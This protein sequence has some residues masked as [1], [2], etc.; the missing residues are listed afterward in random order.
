MAM[1][2]AA[3]ANDG[4]M[5]NGAE[6]LTPATLTEIFTPQINIGVDPAI[7]RF[8]NFHSYGIGWELIDY[9]GR[10]VALHGGAIDGMLSQMA[11]VPKERLGIVVLT[12]TDGARYL[13]DALVAAVLDRLLG[14]EQ[15]D[16]NT[17]YLAR[18]TRMREVIY[19]TPLRKR[20]TRFTQPLGAYAGTYRGPLGDIVVTSSEKEL[21][22][23]Y[24][25]VTG[26]LEHWHYDSFRGHF[27]TYGDRMVTFTMGIDGQ[28]SRLSVEFIGDFELVKAR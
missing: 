2:L 28:P 22:F 1:L 18:G 9:K 26:A 16:W 17:P 7:E 10:K 8:T 5:A 13:P 19:G 24:G 21:Q 12:N 15:A 11:V 20:D 25:V 3:L 27:G 23:T 6:L 4:A 14:G